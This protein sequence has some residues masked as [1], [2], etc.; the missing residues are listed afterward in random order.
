MDSGR[1]EL[2]TVGG[3][4][5]FASDSF[6]ACRDRQQYMHEYIVDTACEQGIVTD[7]GGPVPEQG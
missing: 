3:D 6:R 5:K 1:Y 2:R 7:P 4:V